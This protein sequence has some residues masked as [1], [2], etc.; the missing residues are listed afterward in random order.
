MNIPRKYLFY[1]SPLVFVFSLLFTFNASAI[2]DWSGTLDSSH[3]NLIGICHN[4]D[5]STS[6]SGHA[7]TDYKYLVFQTEN[8]FSNLSPS[9]TFLQFDSYNRIQ[10]NNINPIIVMSINPNTNLSIF[11]GNIS[12]VNSIS[13]WSVIVTLT[14]TFPSGS[15]SSGSLSI[16]ENGTYDVTDYAEAVVDVQNEIIYGDYHQDLI[17]IVHAIYVCGAILLVLYFFYCIYRM[18]IKTTGG[19]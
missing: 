9:S 19:V 5:P 15:S 8:D 16:T 14:D 17:N 2:A 3:Q 13:G 7:C 18:I 1:F 12:G 10:F 11:T 4:T 6:Q